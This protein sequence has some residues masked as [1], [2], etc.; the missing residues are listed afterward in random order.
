MTE[1][2][3]KICRLE[4]AQRNMADAERMV[5]EV[6]KLFV[7]AHKHCQE[8]KEDYNKLKSEVTSLVATN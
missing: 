5:I 7:S 1:L 4:F 3:M 6:Y 8:L 2:E